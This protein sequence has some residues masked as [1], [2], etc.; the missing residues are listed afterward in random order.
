MKSLATLWEL[1]KQHCSDQY[2][3]HRYFGS[4]TLTSYQNRQRQYRSSSN[5][6]RYG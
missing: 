6:T 3:Y 4:W 2:R 5:K 1:M